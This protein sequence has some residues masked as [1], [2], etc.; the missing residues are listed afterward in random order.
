MYGMIYRTV[1]QNCRL[2]SA[3]RST[4]PTAHH[5]VDK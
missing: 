1:L 5:E 2:T 4:D 3:Q